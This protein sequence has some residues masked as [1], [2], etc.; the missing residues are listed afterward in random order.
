MNAVDSIDSTYKAQMKAASGHKGDAK[1]MKN[2]PDITGMMSSA[3]EK[4]KDEEDMLND[5]SGK[6][7]GSDP[8]D[9]IDKEME[10]KP[11]KSKSKSKSKPKSKKK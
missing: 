1:Y 8:L 7:E 3:G 9:S 10:D 5:I 6:S 11:V 2:H 4:D